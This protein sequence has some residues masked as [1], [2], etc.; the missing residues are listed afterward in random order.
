M[1]M[2]EESEAEPA[3]LQNPVF[4]EFYI[5]GRNSRGLSGQYWMLLYIE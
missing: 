4:R 3:P 1:T 5:A 2:S